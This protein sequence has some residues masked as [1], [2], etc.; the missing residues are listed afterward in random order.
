MHVCMYVS[1]HV[2]VYVCMQV[3]VHVCVCTCVPMLHFRQQFLLGCYGNHSSKNVK[4]NP[5]PCGPEKPKEREREL[6][7][8]HIWSPELRENHGLNTDQSEVWSHS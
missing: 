8:K 6:N 2:F 4:L 1:V 7:N 5:T 3:C